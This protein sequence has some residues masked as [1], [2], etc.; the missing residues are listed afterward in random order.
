MRKEIVGS[1]TDL[2]KEFEKLDD[3]KTGKLVRAAMI[4]AREF[5]CNGVPIRA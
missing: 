5:A 2:K 4:N 3:R 1:H